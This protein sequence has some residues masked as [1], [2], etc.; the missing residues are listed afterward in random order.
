MFF[1]FVEAAMMLGRRVAHRLGNGLVDEMDDKLRY[2]A[3]VED[4][5]LFTALSAGLRHSDRKHD[6]AWIDR[7]GVE[8][9]EGSYVRTR[10]ADG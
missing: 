1:N 5:I 6:H 4:G 10:R 3:K 9:A 7:N 8:K 2:F